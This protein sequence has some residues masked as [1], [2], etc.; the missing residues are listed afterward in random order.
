MNE[1]IPSGVA[2]ASASASEGSGAMFDAIADRYD[3]LNRVL[4]LGIDRRWRARTIEALELPDRACTVLDLATG[5]ADLAIGIARRHPAARVIGVDPSAR[6]LVVGRGKVDLDGLADRIELRLGDAQALP[7]DDDSVDATTIAFGI[8]NVPDR[9]RA[10]EEMARVTRP[11]GRVAILELS[12]PRSGLLGPLARFHV[13]RVVPALGAWLSGAR[14]YRYLARSIEAFPSSDRFAALMAA[15]GL[16]VL[17]VRP[18]T[19]G[20][21]TLYVARPRRSGAR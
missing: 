6:M 4:S 18:M 14:E 7:L 13:H 2:A 15:H 21:C 8:R 17:A 1:P 5:T 11:E 19:F 20:V 3:R 16:E 10:L 12:E 9:A